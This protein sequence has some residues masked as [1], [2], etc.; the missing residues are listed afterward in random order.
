[1][2]LE[3]DR[4]H[5][6]HWIMKLIWG[7]NFDSPVHDALEQGIV[8]LDSGCGPGTWSCE[9][10]KEYPKSKFHG[11]DISSRFP[12]AIKPPNCEFHIHNIIHD[13]IFPDNHFG[14]IHQ[15]LLVL[16]LLSSDWEKVVG[17][18]MRLLKPGGWIELSEAV[19]PTC[20]NGGPRI[21]LLLHA[22]SEYGGKMKGLD[23]DVALR[24]DSLLKDAG[25]VNI[26]TRKVFAPL[27]HGGQIGTLFWDDFK[28]GFDALKPVI[29]KIRPDLDGPGLYEKFLEDCAEECKENKTSMYLVRCYGQKPS[30]TSD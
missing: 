5:Q 27:N 15:R 20:E 23:P 19:L 16:G 26:V 21:K 30:S 17:T 12:E 6:Q 14:F 2:C 18:F 1:M 28:V 4:L 22:I 13:P 24:L 10:G 3:D 29:V 11:I 8:V 7:N 25:A 9:L